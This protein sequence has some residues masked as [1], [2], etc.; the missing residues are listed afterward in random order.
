MQPATHKASASTA[1]PVVHFEVIGKHPETLRKYYGRLFGWEFHTGSM[2]PPKEVSEADNYGFVD[3]ITTEDG[4]G[5]RGGVG[6][7]EAYDSHAIFYVAVED[8]E[9]ALKKAER[10]GGT[11]LMG[12]VTK[13]GGGLVVGHLRDPEG[14][15]IGV[16]GPH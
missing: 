10:L 12:P 16:A 15:P 1:A 14:T 3:R 4:T 8:V 7:G 11:R 9:A 6:G 13:P 2:P 5:I